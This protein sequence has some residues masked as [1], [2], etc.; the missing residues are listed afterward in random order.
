MPLVQIAA[1]ADNAAAWSEGLQLFLTAEA[2]EA[3]M[4]GL[5]QMQVMFVSEQPEPWIAA[6]KSLS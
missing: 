2:I 4:L 3:I 5:E 1:A 6:V